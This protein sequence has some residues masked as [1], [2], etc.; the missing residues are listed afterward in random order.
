[1]D[2]EQQMARMQ[3]TLYFGQLRVFHPLSLLQLDHLAA[4]DQFALNTHWQ[5]QAFFQFG[6]AEMN[7]HRF[8]HVDVKA[9]RPPLH[10]DFQMER[11][12]R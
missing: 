6:V 8:G 1:M 10:R 4:H 11:P 3:S 12:A 5:L 9:S 2:N 7:T